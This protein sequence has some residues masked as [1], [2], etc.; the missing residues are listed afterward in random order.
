VAGGAEQK[1]N[2]EDKHLV[3]M[4]VGYMNSSATESTVA[5]SAKDVGL[6]LG[7]AEF[8]S[9]NL[10]GIDSHFAARA[11]AVTDELKKEGVSND[12]V[13][14]WQNAA[15][16]VEQNMGQ[17]GIKSSTNDGPAPTAAKPAEAP[18]VAAS[19][20]PA[21][22]KT[23]T[24][25]T[26]A[27][28][29]DA[30]TSGAT[31]LTGEDQHLVDRA[32]GYIQASAAEKNPFTS[33]KE[34]GAAVGEVEF[35]SGN[36]EGTDPNMA[37]RS[38]A[39]TEELQHLGVNKDVIAHWQSTTEMLAPKTAAS[40][41][42]NASPDEASAAAGAET[43]ISD[44][45]SVNLADSSHT[46]TSSGATET[47]VGDSRTA[48]Q[49]AVHLNGEDKHLVDM[50]VGYLNGA[51]H[52]KNPRAR[53]NDMVNAFAAAEFR[54]GNKEG[55]DPNFGARAAEVTKELGALGVSK[56]VIDEW[57]AGVNSLTPYL[58]KH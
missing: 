31:K 1:L 27:G 14:R 23:A 4:A 15:N 2:G 41:A 42:V 49:S 53:N 37:A 9:G 48:D 57:Q 6:A 33:A 11:A 22:E 7:A 24:A 30:Q 52:E 3:D 46:A 58:G 40:T 12:L 13:D 43:P 45:S 10:P 25:I 21:V 34:F 56:D 28:A 38:K 36:L 47:G 20:K 50:A 55:I 16:T 8:R 51:A 26:T 19:E 44:H 29:A 32:V 35:R 39:V 18:A 5:A 17:A 54:S